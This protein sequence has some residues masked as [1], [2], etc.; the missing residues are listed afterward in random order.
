ME[1]SESI[2]SQGIELKF[3]RALVQRGLQL[4]E[5]VGIKKDKKKGK[6]LI[7]MASSYGSS[8]ANYVLG[9]IALLEDNSDAAKKKASVFYMKAL[10]AGSNY[11]AEEALEDIDE[12]IRFLSETSHSLRYC[13]QFDEATAG[14]FF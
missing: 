11:L 9:D 7:E 5:G 4:F 3:P 10:D 13:A 14:A 8:M 2:I 1:D 12:H 6:E